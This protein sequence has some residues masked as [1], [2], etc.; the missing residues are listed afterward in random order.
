MG[1]LHTIPLINTMGNIWNFTKY[2]AI[3][4]ECSAIIWY[5]Y[6]TDPYHS[7]IPDAMG[8]VWNFTKYVEIP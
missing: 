1:L 2:V 7:H 5:H 6:G 3:P 8:D 4:Y